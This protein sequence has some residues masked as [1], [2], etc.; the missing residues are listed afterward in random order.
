MG[1]RN[2]YEHNWNP[3]YD[4]DRLYDSF[5][6]L[7]KEGRGIHLN[8]EGY[9]IMASAVPLNIFTTYESGLRLYKDQQCNVEEQYDDRDAQNPFYTMN[10]D[11]VR[12]EKTKTIVRYVKNI[13]RSQVLFAMYSSNEYNM[14]IEFIGAEGTKGAYVNGLLA[15]NMVAKITMA[16]NLDRLDS[17]A[18]FKLHLASREYNEK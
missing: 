4:G 2:P 17:K 3:I 11:N 9:R 16:I 1:K 8:A 14:K 13:G 12:R 5:G 6:N 15:P 7:I 10:I 18:S